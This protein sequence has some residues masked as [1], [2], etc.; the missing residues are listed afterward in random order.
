LLE[1]DGR[2]QWAG[3]RVALL[4]GYSGRPRGYGRPDG[5]EWRA[6]GPVD[7]AVG[8]LMAVSRAA[9]D[10]AGLLDEQLFAYVEDVDWSLRIRAAGFECVLV[11]D[12]VATHALAASSGGRASTTPM[13][14]GVR[15]TIVVCE[16]HRPLGPAGTALRRAAVLGA[17]LARAVVVVRSRAVARAVLDGYADARAGRLGTR[18]A[19]RS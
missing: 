14:Y 6:E 10:A 19:A 5:P 11:P 17:F 12:A 7:R 13:Y 16:R 18:S 8:A 15:N 1:P 3:Q 9:I 4:T 2:V